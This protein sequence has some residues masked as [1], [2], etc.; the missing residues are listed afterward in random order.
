M[1]RKYFN[2]TCNVSECASERINGSQYCTT[3]H[4]RYLRHGDPTKTKRMPPNLSN[5]ERIEYHGWTLSDNENLDEPCWIWNGP[6]ASRGYGCLRAVN[7]KIEKAHRISYLGFVGEIE[8]GNMIL[9][10]CDNRAC[11]NPAHLRQGNQSDNMK[12][13]WNRNRRAS[14]G[15][16]INS[17]GKLI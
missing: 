8:N 10:S 11:I 4:T 1:Y 9:H 15:T 14:R 17:L 5:R 13:M 7:G 16:N 12:D 3:H 6:M 2:E